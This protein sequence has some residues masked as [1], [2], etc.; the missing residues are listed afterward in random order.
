MKLD[1]LL[2]KHDSMGRTQARLLIVAGRVKIDRCQCLRIDQEV[3]RFMRVEIDDTILQSSERLL[4]LM[5]N[6]PAGV[7]SA[8]SDLEHRT[9]I[10]LIDDPDKQSL[11]LVGRLD[12]NTTG[13]VLL[14]NDGRW[15][16]SLMD[17][18]RK[19]PKVYRVGTRDPIPDEAVEAFA[20]G[21]YFHTEDLTT[22]PAELEIL[23]AREARLTLHEGRYHQVKRMFHRIGNRVTSLHRERV[24]MI[25]L[26]PDLA[27]GEWRALTAEEIRYSSF[28]P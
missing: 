6:K 16:K 4:H 22:L 28:I 23:G 14:T 10:D 27:P 7:V 11:H 21:F 17:P 5:V 3:D 26:S 13:L 12:R 15:S 19:V 2:A 8:T 18:S 25:E 20:Q 9:V 24:G 1:R